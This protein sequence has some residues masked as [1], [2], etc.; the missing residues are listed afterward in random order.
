MNWNQFFLATAGLYLL[1]YALNL[2]YDLIVSPR[3]SSADKG[4]Y[5]EL[6]FAE[7]TA[8]AVAQLPEESEEVL[9]EEAILEAHTGTL[10]SGELE[11]TGTVSI[12][13]ML[14]QAQSQALELTKAISY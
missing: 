11:C 4:N 8:P 2:L 1:Y 14:L 12:K 9:D 10:S 7:E 13:E 6:V 3:Q 5:P